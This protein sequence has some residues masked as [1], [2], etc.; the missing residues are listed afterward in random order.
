MKSTLWWLG[1]TIVGMAV[2]FFLYWGLVMLNSSAG[3]PEAGSSFWIGQSVLA[4]I[5]M[6]CAIWILIRR[7]QGH[8]RS[9]RTSRSEESR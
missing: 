5:L 7:I 6:A 3:D 8:L 1:T 4:F 2:L 9:K